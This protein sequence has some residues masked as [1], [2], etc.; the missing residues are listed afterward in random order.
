MK[1]FLIAAMSLAASTALAGDPAKC[2]SQ[3]KEFVSECEKAC[4]DQVKKK[5]S[6]KVADACM[7]NCKDFT[8]T[9]EKECANA[10]K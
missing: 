9:C 1:W 7:K 6:Q 4:N 8:K 3:C 5:T 10:K 2:K